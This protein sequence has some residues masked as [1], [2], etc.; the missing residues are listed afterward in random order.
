MQHL[1]GLLGRYDHHFDNFFNEL[2]DFASTAHLLVLRRA[3]RLDLEPPGF[4]ADGRVTLESFLAH[5]LQQWLRRRFEVTIE[6]RYALSWIDFERMLE[7]PLADVQRTP[8]DDRS[9]KLR[10][11]LDGAVKDP[12][13]FFV[14]VV[15]V[16]QSGTNIALL[17]AV[18]YTHLRAHETLMNL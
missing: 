1:F 11:L 5:L 2:I 8:Y 10:V 12:R 13:D 18:S 9:V 7:L 16:Q 15:N 3:V 17:A 14:G 4:T 6:H